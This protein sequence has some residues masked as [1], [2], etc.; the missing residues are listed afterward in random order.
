MGQWT[1]SLCDECFK[2]ERPDKVHPPHRIVEE[3]RDEENCCRCGKRHFSGI[4]YREDPSLY[5]CGGEGG[6]HGP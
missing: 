2:A 4:Y 6:T 5:P 1:H 3:F